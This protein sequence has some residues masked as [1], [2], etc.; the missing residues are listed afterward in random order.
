MAGNLLVRWGIDE[1][2]RLITCNNHNVAMKHSVVSSRRAPAPPQALAD[3]WPALAAGL[4]PAMHESFTTYRDGL[5]DSEP[6]TNTGSST[7]TAATDTGDTG[8]TDAG[9]LLDG[10]L[11]RPGRK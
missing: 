7:T 8:S 1:G 10:L 6:A 4:V 9:V 11:R 5:A 3:A 2:I